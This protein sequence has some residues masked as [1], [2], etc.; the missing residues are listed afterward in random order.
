[1]KEDMCAQYQRL[2]YEEEFDLD[3]V[4]PSQQKNKWID[5]FAIINAPNPAERRKLFGEDEDLV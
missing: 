5:A 2:I 4:S 3:E 1:M